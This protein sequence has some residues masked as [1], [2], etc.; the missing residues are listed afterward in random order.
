[1]SRMGNQLLCELYSVAPESSP[2]DLW[3]AMCKRVANLEHDPATEEELAAAA[4]RI[5]KA[6]GIEASAPVSSAIDTI[7]VTNPDVLAQLLETEF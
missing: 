3:V 5:R 1:M 6:Y 7:L 2:L 4:V